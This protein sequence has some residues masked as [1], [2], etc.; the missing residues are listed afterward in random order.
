MSKRNI[1]ENSLCKKQ[2]KIDG[3]FFSNNSEKRLIAD[4]EKQ[5]STERHGNLDSSEVPLPG[6]TNEKKKEIEP[7]LELKPTKIETGLRKFQ[8]TWLKDFN[9]LEY[10][11]VIL[12]NIS[13]KN[14]TLFS[15]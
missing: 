4:N 3:F 2:K 12:I 11:E 8:V 7:A 14:I 9:W 13:D 5:S 10:K 15:Y 6:E 1:Q